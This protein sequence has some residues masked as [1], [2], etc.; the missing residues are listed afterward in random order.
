MSGETDLY[1]LLRS[2]NPV[3]QPDDYAILTTSLSLADAVALDP[4]GL[5]QEKEG[6]TVILPFPLP[7]NLAE[8]DP[9]R[10]RM[11]T[12]SVHSSLDAVGFLAAITDRLAKHAI[13]TNA[14]AG[15]YHDHLFVPAEQAA[16]AVELLLKMR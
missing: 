7:V 8:G 6:L 11:I 5:F 10:F 16:E 14:V 4:I 1:T 2:M 12:L 15:Y 9:P 3:L 13:S